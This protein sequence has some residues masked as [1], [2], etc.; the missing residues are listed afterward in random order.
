[1]DKIVEMLKESDV[2]VQIAVVQQVVA[3][4]DTNPLTTFT[5]LVLQEEKKQAEEKKSEP[6]PVVVNQCTN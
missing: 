1:M 3:Q 6:A 4:L 2:P 5:E